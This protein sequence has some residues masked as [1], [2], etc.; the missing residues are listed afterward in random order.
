MGDIDWRYQGSLASP[1]EDTGDESKAG[2]QEG[3]GEV[4]VGVEELRSVIAELARRE[5]R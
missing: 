3:D 1:D 5:D 2:D 4:V